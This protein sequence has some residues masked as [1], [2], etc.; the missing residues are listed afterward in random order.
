M[1]KCYRILFAT[2]SRNDDRQRQ[3]RKRIQARV[4][5]RSAGHQPASYLPRLLITDMLMVVNA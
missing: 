1:R 4:M 2:A 5:A 3:D